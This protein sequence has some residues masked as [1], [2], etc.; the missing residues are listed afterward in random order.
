MASVI[1]LPPQSYIGWKVSISILHAL[2]AGCTI[3]RLIHRFRI[4]RIWWDDRLIFIPLVFNILY[5]VLAWIRFSHRVINPLLGSRTYEILNSYWLSLL[6]YLITVWTTRMVLA[7]SLGR[8]FPHKHPARQWSYFLSILMAF[9][10]IGCALAAALS[11]SYISPLMIL[12]ET[13]YC[14]TLDGRYVVSMIILVADNMLCDVLL[15]ISPLL[16]FWRV[17]LPLSERRLVLVFFCGSILTLLLSIAFT[18]LFLNRRIYA[19]NDWLLI[20]IGVFNIDAAV[21]LFASNMIVI[22][23]CF[24][25]ALRRLR[26]REKVVQ[27]STARNR[28]SHFSSP[29]TGP[30]SCVRQSQRSPSPEHLTLTEISTYISSP[31]LSQGPQ[32]SRLHDDI[33]NSEKSE[34]EAVHSLQSDGNFQSVSGRTRLFFTRRN[35]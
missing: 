16:L 14:A 6:P 26:S 29:R 34:L 5:C 11:C 8:I 21:S 30:C 32:H 22:S 35:C 2:S 18:V 15:F 1:I 28:T 20:L 4:H 33:S 10:F 3:Y 31:P 24:Y 27:H 19:G 7:L 9:S 13:T 17:K 12:Y 25:Q 23:T